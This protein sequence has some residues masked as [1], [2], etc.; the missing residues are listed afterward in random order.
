M[1]ARSEIR[2]KRDFDEYEQ[3]ATDYIDE[4]FAA[5]Y[6][7]RAHSASARAYSYLYCIQFDLEDTQAK[8]EGWIDFVD[9]PSPGNDSRWVEADALGVSVLQSILNQQGDP[10]QIHIA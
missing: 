7:M 4:Y 2:E 6:W 5:E 3:E 8:G 9:G 1:G 10:V